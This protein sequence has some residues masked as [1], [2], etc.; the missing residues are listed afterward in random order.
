MPCD[1]AAL[2]IGALFG[3]LKGVHLLGLLREKEKA[4][5]GAFSWTQRTLKLSLGTIWHRDQVCLSWYQ[6]MGHKETVCEA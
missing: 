1:R 3:N 2:S 4:Y 6:I 5:L